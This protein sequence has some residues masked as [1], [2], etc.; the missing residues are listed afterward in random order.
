[1]CCISILFLFVTF[2]AAIRNYNIICQLKLNKK[3]MKRKDYQKPTMMVVQLLHTGMLM[4]SGAVEDS[5]TV[6][7]YTWSSEEEE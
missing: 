3:D 1:M 2:A 6:N 4:T 7:D 5:I